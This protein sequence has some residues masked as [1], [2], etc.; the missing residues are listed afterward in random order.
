MK[1]RYEDRYYEELKSGIGE[2]LRRPNP[3]ERYGFLKNPFPKAGDQT[4]EPCYNQDDVKTAFKDKFLSFAQSEGQ[5]SHRLLILGDHRV[6]KTN[7]LLYSQRQ[8]SKLQNEGVL[9][10]FV[11]LYIVVSSDN[12]LRDVHRSLIV[13]LENRVFLVF[14]ET[15]LRNYEGALFQDSSDFKRAIDTIVKPL[16]P[17]LQEGIDETDVRRFAKWFS[18]EKCTQKELQALGGI[19]SS[20]DTSSL[21]IK[22][23]RDFVNLS[24]RL[25]V[26]KGLIIL[27]DEFE[28]IF[29][30]AVTSS[31]RARYLQDLR[32]F[33]DTMQVGTLLVVASLP[34]ILTDFQRDYP[35][36]KNRL[37]DPIELSP[38][39]DK[40]QAVGYARAY[41]DFERAIFLKQGGE[42]RDYDDIISESEIASTFEE[43]QK[44]YRGRQGMFFDKLHN[45][46]EEKVREQGGAR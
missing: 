20:I 21:A 30:K 40:K 17:K 8:I 35:A 43:V 4:A 28:L 5:T 24:R 38:I 18:G 36:L 9:E 29:G 22:Y 33:I 1:G 15:I 44:E 39:Q 3:F 16:Q 42:D 6:G 45:K 32:H 31:K 10:G 19:F 23:F 2:G 7:F 25:D 13:E 37:G 12:F 41:L 46:V 34:A 14:F 26:F 27:L 11:P